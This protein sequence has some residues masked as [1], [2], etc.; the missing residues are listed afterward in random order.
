MPDFLIEEPEELKKK[1]RLLTGLG[2]TRL[3][4]RVKKEMYDSLSPLEKEGCDVILE[5]AEARIEFGEKVQDEFY[6]SIQASH[7]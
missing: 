1:A 5:Y 2:V 3:A 7:R 6:K 4:Q